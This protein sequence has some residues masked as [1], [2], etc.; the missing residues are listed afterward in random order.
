[1]MTFLALVWILFIFYGFR[2]AWAGRRW[3]EEICG[4]ETQEDLND[5]ERLVSFNKAMAK[6]WV[7]DIEKLRKDKLTDKWEH[8]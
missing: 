6:F 4:M 8:E 7:W 1:M 3:A 2:L 5:Y